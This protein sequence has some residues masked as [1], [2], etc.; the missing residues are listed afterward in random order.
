MPVEVRKWRAD[1]GKLYDTEEDAIIAERKMAVED[2]LTE[3]LRQSDFCSGERDYIISFLMNNAGRVTK[4]LNKL[5][6]TTQTTV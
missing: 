4:A 3:I 1:D 5:W 6:P 2:E